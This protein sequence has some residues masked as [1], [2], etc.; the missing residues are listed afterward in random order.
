MVGAAVVFTAATR[1]G[2]V[3]ASGERRR[4][5]RGGGNSRA[6][7]ALFLGA[8]GSGPRGVAGQLDVVVDAR[9]AALRLVGAGR[10]IGQIVGGVRLLVHGDLLFYARCGQGRLII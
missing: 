9:L 1:T 4:R 2:H 6:L 10:M 7:A 5:D 3:C 8:R